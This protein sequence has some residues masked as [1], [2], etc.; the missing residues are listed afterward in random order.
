MEVMVEMEAKVLL[1]R[2]SKAGKLLLSEE[3][4]KL[5][6]LMTLEQEEA[7]VAEEA[8]ATVLI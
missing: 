1:V 2:H 4:E 8:A 5:R 3:M 7:A 6:L